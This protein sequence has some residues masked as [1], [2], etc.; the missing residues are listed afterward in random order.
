MDASDDD[1]DDGYAEK[2]K[3]QGSSG[4]TERKRKGL[5]ATPPTPQPHSTL[6]CSFSTTA[7]SLQMTPPMAQRS[8][9]SKE[10]T[11]ATG[12]A[13]ERASTLRPSKMLS[14][15]QGSGS[16]SGSGRPAASA[17]ISRT[18]TY[19]LGSTHQKV[20]PKE[21]SLHHR[22]VVSD[23]PISHTSPWSQSSQLH[24]QHSPKSESGSG[25]TVITTT[26]GKPGRKWKNQEEREREK[27][28][29]ERDKEKGAASHDQ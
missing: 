27:I 16:G 26:S 9:V 10:S 5:V 22:R 3:Q 4:T 29:K 7:A 21:R 19:A 1:D 13:T 11:T 12:T 18:L 17:A 23:S 6:K 8:S 14:H 2:Q 24:P 25:P 15:P 28:K 20:P